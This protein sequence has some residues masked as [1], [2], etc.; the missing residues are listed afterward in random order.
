MRD[1][2]HYRHP[3]RVP[4]GGAALAGPYQGGPPDGTGND[5][6]GTPRGG[7][8]GGVPR[9]GYSSSVGTEV[10]GS[11]GRYGGPPSTVRMWPDTQRARSLSR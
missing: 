7:V 3:V 11:T 6:P 1:T 9:E 5:G 8:P 10:T 4:A 2:S